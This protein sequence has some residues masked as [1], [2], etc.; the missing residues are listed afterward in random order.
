MPTVPSGAVALTDAIRAP[1]KQI[2]WF[3]AGHEIHWERPAEYQRVTIE[4]IEAL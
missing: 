4:V 2:F 3:D 1:R